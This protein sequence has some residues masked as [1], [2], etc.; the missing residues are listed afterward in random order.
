MALS[1]LAMGT[2]T[3][4]QD[5]TGGRY[6]TDIFTTVDI[7]SDVNYGSNQSF[8]GATIQLDMDIYEPNGDTETARPLIILAHGGSFIGGDKSDASIVDLCD[9]FAKKGFVCASIGY[10]TG[11]WPIDSVNAVKA[12][13]RAV[14]DMKGAVRFF[15]EDA[16]NADAYKID[17]TQIF[18]GGSSAGAVTALHYAYLDKECELEEFMSTSDI[19]SLGGLEGNSGNAGYS[20][21]VAGVINL[22][23]A[24][25]RYGWIE[26][27]DVPLVSLHGNEDDVVPYGRGEASVSGFGIMYLDGSRMI[28]EHAGTIGVQSNFFSHYGGGHVVYSGNATYMDTTENFIRDFLIDQFGCTEAALQAPNT[29]TGA[30]ELYPLTHC[31]LG[32]SD[33]EQMMIKDIYPNPSNDQI[34]IQFENTSELKIL[35]LIDLSGRTVR[36]Y[37]VNSSSLIIRKNDLNAGVYLLKTTNENGVTNTSKIIFE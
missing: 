34:T 3:I 26:A 4:A 22:C 8:S 28:D 37:K 5:C 13:M 7:T 9:R 27:G 24:I 33:A 31:G 20:T 19:T 18:I 23:G 35:Q 6:A 10:R 29:G 2:T 14:Q 15:Y 11:M 25:A 36:S 12:V 17:T 21:E 16:A 32:F 30:A 1:L